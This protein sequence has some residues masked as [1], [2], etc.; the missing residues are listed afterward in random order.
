[1]INL[2]PDVQIQVLVPPAP[3][4]NNTRSD[5]N[6]ASL[7]LRRDYGDIEA[8]A[9]AWLLA[10]GAPLEVDLLKVPH[11]GSRFSEPRMAVFCVVVR[12]NFGH[13]D[14]RYWPAGPIPPLTCA[15][16]FSAWPFTL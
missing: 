1:L 5:L 4:L 8:E 12:N 3:L 11:H 7:V 10:N 13:P 2:D 15:A 9:Q 6:N 16:W 14:R